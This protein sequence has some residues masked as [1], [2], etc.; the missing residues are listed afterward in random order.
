MSD[1][2]EEQI[3]T[4]IFYIPALLVL[5]WFVITELIEAIKNTSQD[6]KKEK[7]IMECIKRNRDEK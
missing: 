4:S 6:K 3:C 5:M 1:I 2:N 7:L